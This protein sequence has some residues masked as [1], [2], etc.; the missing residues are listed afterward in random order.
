LRVST[1]G[2]FFLSDPKVLRSMILLSNGQK[3]K[4]AF[5]TLLMVPWINLP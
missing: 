5:K 3:Y 4:L 2:I 1:T